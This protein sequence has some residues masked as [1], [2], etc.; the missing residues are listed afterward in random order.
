MA[1]Q[2]HCQK[3][4]VSFEACPSYL[5]EYGA[6]CNSTE[7]SFSSD[8]WWSS[9]VGLCRLPHP[10]AR[11][12]HEEEGRRQLRPG[13]EAHLQKGSDNRDLRLKPNF[14]GPPA[15]SPV[16]LESKPLFLPAYCKTRK[17]QREKPSNKNCFSYS[18]TSSKV[19]HFEME[20]SF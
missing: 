10:S 15:C 2:F 5:P 8:C 18:T 20:S 6:N 12:S 14:A 9:G 11:L 16:P 13:K 7:F 17:S 1:V 3:C 4:I 19:V